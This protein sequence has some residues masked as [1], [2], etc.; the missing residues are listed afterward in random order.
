MLTINRTVTSV[1]IANFGTEDLKA[2][3]ASLP[4]MRGLKTVEFSSQVTGFA[5]EIGNDFIAAME[6]NTTLERL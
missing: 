1:H 5:F 3:A 4:H 2:F 6:Q